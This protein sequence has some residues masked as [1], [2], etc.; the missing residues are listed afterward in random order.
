MINIYIYIHTSPSCLMSVFTLKKKNPMG[1]IP[2]EK[3]KKNNCFID[4]RSILRQRAIHDKYIYY[5]YIY[6]HTSPACLMS[7]FTL[8]PKKSHGRNSGQQNVKKHQKKQQQQ[9][10]IDF[11][12]ILR[13]RVIHDKYIY[14]YIYTHLPLA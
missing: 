14:I 8:Y 6:T 9:C 5:I 2:G 1:K 10:F 3:N 4:F 12:S 13:Q 7:V 11:R